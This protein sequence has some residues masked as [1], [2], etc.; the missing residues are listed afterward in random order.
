MASDRERRSAP[1]PG[2]LGCLAAVAAL[3]AARQL[4]A[5]GSPPPSYADRMNLLTYIA[6]DGKQHPVTTPA[7][8]ERR[9]RH[10]VASMQL[11]MGQLP[12]ASRRVPLD[13]RTLDTVERPG[14]T[15][16]TIAFAA[17]KGDRVPACL[18]LPKGVRGKAPA[19]LCLH[20]TSPLGKGVVVG[21]GP[22][23]NRNYAEELA[24]RGY[25]AL[26]PDYPSLGDNKTD[27]Y[28]LGYASCT[29]KGIW[30][31]MRAVDLLV[32]LPQVDPA[33]IGCIGHSLGG[34]NAMFVA[35]F[36]PRVKA[37]VSSC[38]FNTFAK[39]MGGNLTGWAGFRYMPRIAS[40]YGSD[41]KKMP[42]EF[43]EVVAALAPRPFFVNAP[44]GD[45]NFEV[46]GVR[47][48][49]AAARPVYALLGAGKSLVVQYP[50]AG[51]DFPPGVRR[52]AYEFLGRA[53]ACSPRPTTPPPSP[54]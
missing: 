23:P 5:G 9:R 21:L 20:P 27:P 30:N 28:K 6:A 32:S 2:T 53:L 43:T 42:F 13:V 45:S 33:R 34:H 16:K 40:R 25:V 14:H 44:L 46:S 39:Y 36:D 10:V 54:R 50:D 29:M 31:H 35:V 22:R 11:V 47:D 17:E 48:C 41:P 52:A 26:A 51:H 18:L 7:Q 37:V 49:I 12:D 4:C 24:D 19:V 38:G 3:A 15:R 1:Y 8:W